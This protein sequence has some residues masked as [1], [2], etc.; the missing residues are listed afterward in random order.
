MKKKIYPSDS[1]GQADHDW[2]QSRFSFSFADYNN[3]KRM[4]FG[5][6]R[7]LNDDTIAPGKGF[8]MH[9][10]SNM[11]I[12]TITLKGELAHKDDTGSEEVIVPGQIQ[13]MSAGTGITHSEY[14][15]S[16]EKELT[17]FQ[18]WIETNKQN[19]EPRHETKT[20][21]LEKNK[22]VKVVSG[23]KDSNT[24][25][26]YQDASIWLEKF[27]KNSIIQLLLRHHNSIKLKKIN[28]NFHHDN[29]IAM[30]AKIGYIFE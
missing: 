10:H 30:L 20:L 11:E 1:R 12:I 25:F 13:V 15:H 7:V 5:V 19:V 2:L 23:D 22:L 8:G 9:S 6:L 24:L 18:I 3:P 26:I 17:L 4:G 16:K 14:N 27:D 29:S 21:N 28:R